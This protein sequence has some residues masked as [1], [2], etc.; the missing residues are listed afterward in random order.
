M[1][2]DNIKK[3]EEGLTIKLNELTASKEQIIELESQLNL[4]KQLNGSNLSAKKV[5]KP[6]FV[7]I[8]TSPDFIFIL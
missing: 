8:K 3:L 1:Y 6:F 4:S 7:M 2:K 5:C